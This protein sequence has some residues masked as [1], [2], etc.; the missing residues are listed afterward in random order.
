MAL[1][2]CPWPNSM[3]PTLSDEHQIWPRPRFVFIRLGNSVAKTSRSLSPAAW[4]SKQH[5]RPSAELLQTGEPAFCC[6]LLQADCNSLAELRVSHNELVGLP[7]ELS[8]NTRLRMLDAGSNRIPNETAVM[9]S[10]TKSE[11]LLGKASAAI[12]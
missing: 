12:S 8:S 3:K 9:V 11:L 7:Q 5:A 10:G 2:G 4:E 6:S 1:K